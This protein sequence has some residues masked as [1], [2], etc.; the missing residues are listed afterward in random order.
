MLLI[1]EFD[2][3]INSAKSGLIGSQVKV[4]KAQAYAILDQMRSTIPEEIKQARWINKERQEMLAEAKRESERI[5]EA[6]REERARLVDPAEVEKLAQRRAD[7]ILE[8]ARG[9]ERQIRLGAEDFAD[10]ILGS[11]ESNLERFTAAIQRGRDRLNIREQ[12]AA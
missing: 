12:A 1:D 6:A 8:D 4:D 7:K 2:D 10:G 11:L 3:A 5:L 9:R